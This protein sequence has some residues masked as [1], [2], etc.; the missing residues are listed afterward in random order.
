MQPPIP[1]IVLFACA[2]LLVLGAGLLISRSERRRSPDKCKRYEAL[3]VAYK[4]ACWCLVSPLYAAAVI[5]GAF[6]L[7]GII[8][9]LVLEAACVRWYRKAGLW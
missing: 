2:Y 8:A 3:P 4:L 6:V 7:L 5:E 1:T 9:H